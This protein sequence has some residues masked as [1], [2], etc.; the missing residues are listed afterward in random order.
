MLLVYNIES[1]IFILSNL[2]FSYFQIYLCFL[3]INKNSL[4]MS[5]SIELSLKHL[6]GK[7]FGAIPDKANEEVTSLSAPHI[8]S[9]NY[10][11]DAGLHSA[12]SHLPPVEFELENGDRISIGILVSK[13]FLF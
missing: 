5:K 6:Q 8:D 11:L 12:V 2:F 10:F 3:N 1:L 9:F 13:L 7:D 4:K